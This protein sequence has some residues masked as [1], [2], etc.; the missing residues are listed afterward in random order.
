MNT[1]GDGGVKEK[2]TIHPLF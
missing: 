2:S 1:S